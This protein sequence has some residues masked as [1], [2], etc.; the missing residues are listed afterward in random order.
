MRIKSL[1]ITAIALLPA[2]HAG[3]QD[4]ASSSVLSKGKWAKI[5]VTEAGIY[6][7]DYSKI[8]EMGIANPAT[9]VLYGNNTGQLSFYNDG[10][11]PDDLRKIAVN[12]VKGSDGIFNEGDYMFFYAE[13]THRWKYQRESGN[14]EFL[15]HCYS[16]TAWYFLTSE[17]AGPLQVM[18]EAA[19][20]Q[21]HNRLS[22]ATDVTLRHEREEVNLIRSGREWYQQVVPGIENNVS[23]GLTDLILTERIRY[24]IRVL[25]RS[26]KPVTF[27]LRQGSE[28]LKTMSVAPVNMTDLNV[29][30][31]SIAEATDSC[32]PAS[33][34]PAFSLSFSA[35]GNLAATGYIDYVDFLARA[36]LVY[37]DRQLFISD[38]RSAGE[39]AVTR[40]TIEGPSSLIVWDVTDPYAPREIQTSSSSGNNCPIV[41][42]FVYFLLRP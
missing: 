3:S 32:L 20:S 18:T 13:G 1:V 21:L 7:L 15:R 2:L 22:A 34:A 14:Y 8:R 28:E 17:P 33:A 27:T 41:Y 16:D 11:A 19:P 29:V 4:Y 26:D 12:V 5:A 10:S 9:V 36:R 31:A 37:R 42:L 6:R 24:A 38:S 40:F 25:G 30:Y 35:N 39:S 23:A